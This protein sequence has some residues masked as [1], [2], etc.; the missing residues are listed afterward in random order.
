MAV[1][2]VAHHLAYGPERRSSRWL[3]SLSAAL[4]FLIP[5]NPAVHVVLAAA[6]AR[7]SPAPPSK[8][9]QNSQPSAA[10]RM[11]VIELPEAWQLL[12]RKM[13][14]GALPMYQA[15][16]AASVIDSSLT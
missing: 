2:T 12:L 6:I 1:P 13:R 8:A 4:D 3:G 5:G 9:G 16:P 10:R 14:Y 11:S 7:K 15:V